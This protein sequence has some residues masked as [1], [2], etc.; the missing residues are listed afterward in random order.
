MK[1]LDRW[2][3]YS[4]ADFVVHDGGVFS[5]NCEIYLFR[6][7]LA[8]ASERSSE[9]RRAD[10]LGKSAGEDD[11]RSWE[12]ATVRGRPETFDSSPLTVR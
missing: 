7:S 12:F 9:V 4:F 8:Q 2:F 11:A 10:W 6:R 5:T 3:N 1:I